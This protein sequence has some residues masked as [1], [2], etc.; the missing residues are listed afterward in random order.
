MESWKKVWR[1]GFVPQFSVAGLQALAQALRGDDARL[2]QGATTSPPPL[3]CVQNWPVEATCPVGFMGVIEHGGF[4]DATV[5]EVE[6]FFA[7]ACFD[8]DQTLGEPAAVRFFLNAWDDMPREEIRR[9]L[10]IEV[11]LELQTRSVA[12]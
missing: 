8:A 2:I 10:L 4:G 5:A 3:T 1:N 12:A 7:K 11:E 6:Q 9:E